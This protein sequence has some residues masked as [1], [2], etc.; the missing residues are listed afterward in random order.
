[1]KR[2]LKS[3]RLLPAIFPLTPSHLFHIIP[4]LPATSAIT[5]LLY[6]HLQPA[7]P[8][9]HLPPTISAII[10]IIYFPSFIPPSLNH[11]LP[12]P[13]ANTEFPLLSPPY[14]LT[15]CYLGLA[16]KLLFFSRS[17]YGRKPGYE[18]ICAIASPSLP[19][20]PPL[21]LSL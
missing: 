9:F 8:P 3:S 15:S 6:S 2:Q 17:T 4:L 20:S 14:F 12:L 18:A 5:P 10:P 11:T 19:P 7:P 21:L 13:P 16:P 1:M